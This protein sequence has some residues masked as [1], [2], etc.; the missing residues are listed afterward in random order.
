VRTLWLLRHAKSSWD[1]PAVADHERPLAPRGRKAARRMR[2]WASEHRVQPEIVLCS[3]AVRARATLELVLPALRSPQVEVE[4]RLYHTS[5]DA[6]LE[7]L[8]ELRPGVDSVLL[9]GHN[10]GFHGLACLLAPPGP[11]AF[12]TAALAELRL[13]ID[14]WPETRPGCGLL[15]Q[16]VLP[17]SLA[18]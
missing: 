6:L 14:E 4:S 3:S 5:A 16:L 1:D 18:S 15:Q 8:R 11:D 10:P 12:P 7:R 13:E 2:R 9:V 17:R